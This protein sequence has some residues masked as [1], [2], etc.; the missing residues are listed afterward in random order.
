MNNAVFEKT[1][2]N[3]REH[4]DIKLV[5]TEGRKDYLISELNYHTKN[6]HRKLNNDRNEKKNPKKTTEILMNK[7]SCLRISVLHLSK[8]I[9]VWVLVWLCKIKIW[10]KSK[11][12]LYGYT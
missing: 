2:E 6:Y 3:T 9:N 1:M 4:R 12:V 11:I 5:T 10:W 8:N 7:S